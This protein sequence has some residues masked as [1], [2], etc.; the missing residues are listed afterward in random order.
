MTGAAVAVGHA[1]RVQ[2]AAGLKPAR[3]SSRTAQQIHLPSVKRAT[4]T[5]RSRRTAHDFEHF[6]DRVDLLA[7][8]RRN[9]FQ[10]F[11]KSLLNMAEFNTGC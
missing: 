6:G 8:H 7:L 3:Y 9:L 4:A 11:A 1:F 5:N 10:S 2:F